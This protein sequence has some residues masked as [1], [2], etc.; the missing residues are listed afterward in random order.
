MVMVEPLLVSG[1]LLGLINGKDSKRWG[2]WSWRSRLLFFFINYNHKIF[3]LDFICT[4]HR[5]NIVKGNKS[6][7]HLRS[8]WEWRS[9]IGEKRRTW[10]FRFLIPFRGLGARKWQWDFQNFLRAPPHST[11][12]PQ[13]VLGRYPHLARCPYPLMAP[14]PQLVPHHLCH[15][16]LEHSPHYFHFHNHQWQQL[17]IFCLTKVFS[18]SIC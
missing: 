18:S 12:A 7:T 6:F 15:P 14:W 17:N 10:K 1:Y 4:I 9:C 16:Y 13:Y 11:S 5:V 2:L 8:V 3:M